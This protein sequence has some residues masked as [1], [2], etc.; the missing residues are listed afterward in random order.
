MKIT[1]EELRDLKDIIFSAKAGDAEDVLLFVGEHG[2][3]LINEILA[4]R[5]TAGQRPGDDKGS[6]KPGKDGEQGEQGDEE[7]I[8]NLALHESV[9]VTN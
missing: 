9:A 3:Q 8:F 6:E 7:R 5:A 1:D 2:P 4:H